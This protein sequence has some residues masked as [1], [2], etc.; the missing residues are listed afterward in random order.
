MERR[1]F[2]RLL[3]ALAAFPSICSGC[4][5][6]T[7]T[8]NHQQQERVG[9][10]CD[11]CDIM[12]K[13]M[14]G[15]LKETSTLPDWNEPGQ[16]MIVQ[17]KVFKNDGKTPAEDIIVYFYH[18]DHRGYYSSRLGENKD[19]E[20]GHIRGWI[21]TN[22]NGEYKIQTTRPAHYPNMQNPEHIHVIIKEPAINEYWID[23]FVFTDDPVLNEQYKKRQQQR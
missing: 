11:G 19:V 22:K 1:Y 23:S 20:H 21:K 9:G 6:N 15:E 14:P 13:D 8:P 7:T 3:P 10:A 2:I 18:T 17:G 12:Y 5:G 16:K 4:S